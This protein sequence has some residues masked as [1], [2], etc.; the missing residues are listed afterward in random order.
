MQYKYIVP[1]IFVDVVKPTIIG[2]CKIVK[3]S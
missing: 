1:G 3:K 2:I